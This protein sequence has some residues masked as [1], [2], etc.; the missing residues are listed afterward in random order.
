MLRRILTAVV[1]IP[2]VV[3]LV[4]WGPPLLL[5][6]VAAV[7]VIV[8]LHEFFTLGERVSMH[9]F[10]NWTMLCAAGLFYAQYA[11]GMVETHSLGGGDLLIRDAARGAVSLELVFLVFLFGAVSIGLAT[12]RPLH[13]VLPAIGI[14]AAG[15]LFIAF[16]LSYLVRINEIERDGRQLVLFT[17]C[18]IWAGDMLAYFVGR[19]LGRMPMAPALSPKKTW[20]GAIANVIASLLVAVLFA[21]WMQVETTSLLVVA[22][23]ANIAGQMGDLI[24]SAYK[25]GAVV[26]DSGSLLPGHGGMLDRV[27]SLILAAP[28][29][30]VAWQY[31]VAR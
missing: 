6:G 8:A 28:V 10:R 7:V 30:W 15:L 25:R 11:A 9:G 22:G 5:A 27:D 23:L 19:S 12:R 29:V 3:A 21:K 18:L 4:W 26:K 31:L 1:L 24:E 16:P 14:S 2:I 20:E 13:D 17:L